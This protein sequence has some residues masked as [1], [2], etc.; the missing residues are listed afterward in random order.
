MDGSRIRLAL[1]LAAA[2][3]ALL[4][5][6]ESFLEFENTTRGEVARYP[7]DPGEAFSV[8]YIHSIYLQ[9]VTEEFAVGRDGEVILTGVCSE[10]GAVQEYFGFEDPGPRHAM[11]RPMRSIVFR[12]AAGDAQTLSVGG[13]RIPFLSLGDHGDRI[14]A[15]LTNGSMAVRALERVMQALRL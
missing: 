15:R 9:P 10:C 5:R 8:T 1:I 11:R 12:V 2:C 4:F 3:G 6:P 7:V 14:E 13:R